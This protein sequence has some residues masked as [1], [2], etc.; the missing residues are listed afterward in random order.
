M[1]KACTE[2]GRS[3]YKIVI[4]KQVA[5]KIFK[6][7]QKDDTIKARTKKVFRLLKT[8]PNYPGLNTHKASSKAKNPAWASWVNGELRIIWDYGEDNTIHILD[9]GTH[10]EVYL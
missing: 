9:F 8:Y 2:Q 4:E 10:K 1:E 6:Y 7:T 3:E 5:V